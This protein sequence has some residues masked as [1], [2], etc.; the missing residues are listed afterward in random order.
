MTDF[1]KLFTTASVLAVLMLSASA[2]SAGTLC[3]A[4]AGSAFPPPDVFRNSAKPV[5]EKLAEA[6]SRDAIPIIDRIFKDNDIPVR[7]L[8]VMKIREI[9]DGVY[10]GFAL[11]EDDVKDKAMIRVKMELIE[12][13]L[14]VSADLDSL[15]PLN[16]DE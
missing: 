10:E 7:C 8:R 2:L 9:G 13:F 5:P 16:A 6:L 4:P 11:L 12:N 14:S 15:S 1:K 3:A